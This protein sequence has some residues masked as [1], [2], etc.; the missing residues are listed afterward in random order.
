MSFVIFSFV[1]FCHFVILSFVICHF[2]HFV[3]CLNLNQEY[4]L[5][6]CWTTESFCGRKNEFHWCC[7]KCAKLWTLT[8]GQPC[9]RSAHTSLVCVSVC[10]CVCECVC[11]CEEGVCTYKC[12][13]VDLGGCSMYPVVWV[14][15]RVHVSPSSSLSLSLSLSSTYNKHNQLLINRDHDASGGCKFWTNFGNTEGL[16]HKLIRHKD[17]AES[18]LN[19]QPDAR[20]MFVQGQS[21][22][23]SVFLNFSIIINYFLHFL[24]N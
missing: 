21:W 22:S 13:C 9:V 20:M 7:I 17:R 18:C 19:S 16:L 4:E 24:S 5:V 3:I 2:C 14:C 23:L 11:E 12:V 15:V 6:S 1:L 8:N 10:G